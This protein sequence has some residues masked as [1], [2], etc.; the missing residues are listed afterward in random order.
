MCVVTLLCS[1][2]P[3]PKFPTATLTMNESKGTLSCETEFP[4]A[5]TRYAHVILAVIDCGFP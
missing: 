2:I 4:A 1:G 3:S 5:V